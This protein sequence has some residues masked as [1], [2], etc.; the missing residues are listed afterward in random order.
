MKFLCLTGICILYE[1]GKHNGMTNVKLMC[2]AL[3][4]LWKWFERSCLTG[5]DAS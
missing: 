3:E 1:F 2:I 5:C 4:V